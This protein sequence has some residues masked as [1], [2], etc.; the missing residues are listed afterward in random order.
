MSNIITPEGI[1]N[2][3]DKSLLYIYGEGE[4]RS[5][6]EILHEDLVGKADF[7]ISLLPKI[8]DRLNAEE[9]VQYIIGEADFYSLKFKVDA[10]VLIPRQETEELVALFRSMEK[11]GRKLKV[12][13]IGTGSGCIPVT[14]NYS[15]PRA[16]FTAIDVSEEALSIA[17]YNADR[18]QRKIEF[19]KID[20]CNTQDWGKLGNF[21][22][23]IS[24]PPYIGKS[25][26][27]KLANNV[28]QY[29]PH[30]ALFSPNQDPNFFYRLIKQ[31]SETKLA[32][33]GRVYL[34][35]NE[36]NAQEVLEIFSTGEYQ[37]VKIVKDIHQKDRILFA[38]KNA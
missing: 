27:S 9:P 15:H 8:I 29:E 3:L 34:E 12:L 6:C 28:I 17:R 18:H 14:I 19:H 10:S 23:L 25:E 33:S 11:K 32:P 2:R 7:D 1:F 16:N 4:L 20:F 36:F 37:E 13:D 38:Q 31:F 24:N 22:V 30:I 21:D 26:S 35:L 5:I